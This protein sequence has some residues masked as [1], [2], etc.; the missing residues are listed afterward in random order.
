MQV[1]TQTFAETETQDQQEFIRAFGQRMM[2]TLAG[3]AAQPTE[4][5]APPATQAQ[6]AKAPP[7]TVPGRHPGRVPAPAGA[8]PPTA[9]GEGRLPPRTSPK[10]PAAEEAKP[11]I[12]ARQEKQREERR[13]ANL[14]SRREGG[15]GNEDGG[16]QGEGEDG[17]EGAQVD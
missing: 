7:Q 11:I 1:I 13:A 5:Q 8:T 15:E 14:D 17:M 9:D 3:S 2:A 16:E 4:T 12:L 6:A 10:A